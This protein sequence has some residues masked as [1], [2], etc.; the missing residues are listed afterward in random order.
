MRWAQQTYEVESIP[1]N[2]KEDWGI[3]TV[4]D[5][6]FTGYRFFPHRVQGE[7]FFLTVLRKTDHQGAAEDD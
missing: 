3:I 5:K 1:L 7:G 6:S 2:V 4:K